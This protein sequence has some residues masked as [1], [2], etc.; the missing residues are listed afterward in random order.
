MENRGKGVFVPMSNVKISKTTIDRLAGTRRDMFIGAPFIELRGKQVAIL[1]SGSDLLEEI[2]QMAAA[3]DGA[4][5]VE[6]MEE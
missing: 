4:D 5:A 6:H 3:V 2:E 1:Q